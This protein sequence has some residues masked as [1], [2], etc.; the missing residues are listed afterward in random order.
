MNLLRWDMR[1]DGASRVPG[2]VSWGGTT[3]GPLAAPGTYRV[4]FTIEGVTVERSFT[5]A[6]HPRIDTPQAALDEQF[7]LLVQI[8]DAI[9]AAHDAVNSIRAARGQIDAAVARAEGGAGAA[10]IAEAARALKEKL[11][12]IEET[13]IQT[14]SEAPQDPLNFPIRLNDKIG[15]LMD[16]VEGDYPVT[17]PARTVFAKLRG[18]LDEQLRRL[19]TAFAEDVAAFNALVRAHEVPAVKAP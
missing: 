17:A 12:A 6:R 19:E 13:L 3:R 9:D 14:K 4:R 7:A 1:G 5:I 11:A 8:R 10:E 2:A 16:V 18:E 15:A